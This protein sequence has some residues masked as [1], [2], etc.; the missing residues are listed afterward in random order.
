MGR[1]GGMIEPKA[2]VFDLGVGEVGRNIYA[3]VVVKVDSVHLLVEEEGKGA[4]ECS[5]CPDMAPLFRMMANRLD[6]IAG[7][8][9]RRG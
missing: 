9:E 1:Q 5:L 3:E 2:Q 7:K 4:I 6:E 8:R